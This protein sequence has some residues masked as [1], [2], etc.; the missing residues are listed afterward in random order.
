M[1]QL[2]RHQLFAAL[3]LLVSTLHVFAVEPPTAEADDALDYKEDVL[4][5]ESSRPSATDF[6]WVQLVSGEWLKGE[7]KALY[8]DSLEFDSSELDLLQID[9]EDVKYLESHIPGSVYIEYTGT[10]YGYLQVNQTEVII[11]NGDTKKTYP[12]KH[13]VSLITGEMSESNF[14]SAKIT[15]GLNIAKGNNDQIDYSAKANIKRRTP[16]SRIILDYIGNITVVRDTETTNNHRVTGSWDRYKTRRFFYRP[17]FGEYFRDP[18]LNTDRRITLSTGLGYTLIDTSKTNWDVS[19]GPGVQTTRFISVEAGQDIEETTPAL[20]IATDFDHEISS[21]LDFIFKYN[22]T[23]VDKQSGGYTHHT[24]T[25]FESELTGR[26]DL[27]VSFVW[28]YISE[29][30]ANED[31]TIPFK[32]DVRLI[33]GVTYEY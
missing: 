14:W 25:T 27:D 19:G 15:L 20:T 18:F 2:K 22:L 23:L 28:D 7:I 12:R 30:T 5:W 16:R 6:D 33:L 31:G 4:T 24:V 32:N 21:A 9:W 29:P 8:N 13:L 26:L 1:F 10:V 17:L 11:T 3:C